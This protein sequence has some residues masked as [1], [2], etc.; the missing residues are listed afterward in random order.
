MNT[1]EIDG[2]QL[3]IDVVY[4]DSGEEPESACVNR[5]VSTRVGDV[6][7]QRPGDDWRAAVDWAVQQ[8]TRNASV[9]QVESVPPFVKWQGRS[10]SGIVETQPAA[11]AKREII[12]V[13]VSSYAQAFEIDWS[14]IVSPLTKARAMGFDI[15]KLTTPPGSSVTVID[16]APLSDATREAISVVANS[17][18]V[19][20]A[21][22]DHT[23][24]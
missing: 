5:M 11:S 13:V 16:S 21:R 1:I 20:G 12:T 4:H 2:R 10:S 7:Y 23:E 19:Q 3:L 18:G 17:A 14:T 24:D 22:L 9:F 8:I 6:T 15:S